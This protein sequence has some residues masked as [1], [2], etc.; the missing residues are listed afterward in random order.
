MVFIKD[1]VELDLVMD[2]EVDIEEIDIFLYDMDIILMKV[3][4]KFVRWELMDFKLVNLKKFC[5][6]LILGYKCEFCERMINFFCV[7]VLVKLVLDY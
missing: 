7:L 4:D 2:V 6:M 5:Y 3:V 1:L